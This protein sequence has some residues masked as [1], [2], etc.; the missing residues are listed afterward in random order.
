MRS[1]LPVSSVSVGVPVTM[2]DSLKYT[3]TLIASPT[4]YVPFGLV[5]V[6]FVTAG[7]SASMTRALFAPSEPAAPGAGSV[8]VASLP[9]PSRIVPPA[10]ANAA[11]FL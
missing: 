7:A 2:T 4:L 11:E 9:T 8:S 5:D 3:C 1:V 6:T 10:S